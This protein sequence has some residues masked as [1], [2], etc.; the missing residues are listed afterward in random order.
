MSIPSFSRAPRRRIK[1]R[2]RTAVIGL[3]AGLLVAPVLA[4]FA[5][6]SAEAAPI[7]I[8]TPVHRA[9]VVFL[10]DTSGVGQW[11]STES[12][13]LA[14]VDQS[15][16]RWVVESERS[17]SSFTRV[18]APVRMKVDCSAGN[19]W[20]QSWDESDTLFPGVDFGGTSGNHLIAIGMRGCGSGVGSSGG[21]AGLSAGGKV[22]IENAPGRGTQSLLHEL[23]HNFGLGHSH[24][25]TCDSDGVRQ[26]GGNESYEIMGGTISMNPPQVAASL[27][28]TFREDLGILQPCEVADV[29]LTAGQP[30]STSTFDLHGRGQAEGTRGL[31]VTSPTGEV[32]YIQWRNRQGRDAQA[33]YGTNLALAQTNAFG[34]GIVIQRMEADNHIPI[35]QAYPKPTGTGSVFALQ[36]GQS[37]ARPDDGLQIRVDALTPGSDPSATARVTLTLSNSAGATVLPAQAGAVAVRGGSSTGSVL[38]ADTTGWSEGSCHQY[39][40]FDDGV[41]IAGARGQ[42]YTVPDTADGHRISVRVT[43]FLPGSAQRV[44]ASTPVLIG[45]PADTDPP[46]TTLTSAAPGDADSTPTFAFSADEAAAFECAIDDSA[47]A[48]CTSPHTVDAVAPGPHTF[49]VR[50]TDLAGN[51]DASPATQEF[52]VAADPA[53]DD[54]ESPPSSEPPTGSS[55]ASGVGDAESGP[56]SE[57]LASSGGAAPVVVAL[58]A[59]ISAAAGVLLAGARRP[60][61]TE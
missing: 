29:A 19:A 54:A 46:E 35:L 59:L 20:E 16:Q 8:A 47:F 2:R 28:T 58:I 11:R 9:Y 53:D 51:A 38:T 12:E 32:Y 13:L 57:V 33:Y 26:W 41:E 31:R 3:L 22:Y 44:V 60:P 15:L 50:A 4:G 61:A 56:A 23:G 24:Y 45:A 39:Q 21:D 34:P 14:L 40:W 36:A 55:G 49:R 27:G 1:R 30:S 17:I 52:V 6:S 5:P 42:T 7:P 37:Y 43:G 48:V 25:E 10:D 18:G